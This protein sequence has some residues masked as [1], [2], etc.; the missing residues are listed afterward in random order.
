MKAGYISNN[1][2]PVS[3]TPAFYPGFR[4][5]LVLGIGSCPD[6][7]AIHLLCGAVLP[8]P[9]YHVLTNKK[10]EEKEKSRIF[11]EKFKKK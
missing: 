5:T 2:F 3:T 9:V 1:P 4:L 11:T 10:G 7:E 6:W 8:F